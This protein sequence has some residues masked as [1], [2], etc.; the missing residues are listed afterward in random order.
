MPLEITEPVVSPEQEE[1]FTEDQLFNP[2]GKLT[3]EANAIAQFLEEVDWEPLFSDPDA[4]PF[5]TS[6]VIPVVERDDRLIPAQEG[7]T[8]EGELEVLSIDGTVAAELIDEDDFL[9]LFKHYMREEYPQDTMEERLTRELFADLLDEDPEEGALRDI[10]RGGSDWVGGPGARRMN[11]KEKAK[12]KNRGDSFL[13]RV[14]PGTGRRRT[15]GADQPA[16][17]PYYGPAAKKVKSRFV[18]SKHPWVGK[19]MKAVG[20]VSPFHFKKDED[21]QD[22]LNLLAQWMQENCDPAA[23]EAATEAFNTAFE[24]RWPTCWRHSSCRKMNSKRSSSRTFL[25]K[26]AAPC[27]F[28]AARRSAR[29]GRT[30]AGITRSA[31]VR[32]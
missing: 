27:R 10:L 4:Q 21:T 7:Q 23:D 9:A 12:K 24:T 17:A 14:L 16:L 28:M 15:E 18:P 26:L 5:I 29:F 32:C 22:E 11:A 30:K 8:A 20:K 31:W 3:L 2:A 6:E 1:A 25:R 19:A 13:N